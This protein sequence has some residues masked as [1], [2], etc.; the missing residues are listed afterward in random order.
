M[1]NMSKTK[2]IILVPVYKEHLT[3]DEARSFKRLKSVL[4]KH[5][6]G[7]IA[8]NSLDVSE[9][10][11]IWGGALLSFHFDDEYFTD[12]M[13]Y[14]KLMN[15]AFFYK[16]FLPYEYMLIYQLDCWVFRDEL[17]EWCDKGYDYI[18]APFFVKWFSDRGLYVGNGGFSLR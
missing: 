17:D 8:P 14:G 13:A 10:H 6:V 1:T 3:N 4:G 18:G 5:Q 15:S 9:Y 16:A 12:R 7:L 2:C 11:T